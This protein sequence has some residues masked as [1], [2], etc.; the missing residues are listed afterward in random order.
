MLRQDYPSLCYYKSQG[1]LH[2]LGHVRITKDTIVLQR[3]PPESGKYSFQVRGESQNLHLQAKSSQSLDNWV[4]LIEAFVDSLREGYFQSQRGFSDRCKRFDNSNAFKGSKKF[5]RSRQHARVE[6]VVSEDDGG[7]DGTESSIETTSMDGSDHPISSSKRKVS[8]GSHRKQN[9]TD[10]SFQL[11]LGPQYH[12]V[13]EPKM[14]FFIRLYGY[15]KKT[16][17]LEEIGCTRIMQSSRTFHSS[18][19]N[20]IPD[21][22]HPSFSIVLSISLGRYQHLQLALFRLTSQRGHHCVGIGHYSVTEACT[23]RT[24]VSI[25]LQKTDLLEEIDPF[26]KDLRLT[27]NHFYEAAE[28]NQHA[29]RLLMHLSPSQVSQ[30]LLSTSGIDMANAKYHSEISN[31]EKELSNTPQITNDCFGKPPFSLHEILRIP[32]ET[33][34]VPI[35]FLDYLESKALSRIQ[36][37][38][39]RMLLLPDDAMCRSNEEFEL[40]FHQQKQNEYVKHRQFLLKKE[41]DL[42]SEQSTG[43]VC[44]NLARLQPDSNKPAL[45]PLDPPFKRSTFRN[46]EE[47][48]YVAT[49]M[50]NQFMVLSECAYKKNQSISIACMMS[51]TLTM[52]CPAAHTKGFNTQACWLEEWRSFGSE[53]QTLLHRSASA[54]LDRWRNRCIDVKNRHCQGRNSAPPTKYPFLVGPDTMEVSLGKLKQRL[55]M[56]DRLD[57][58]ASQILSAGIACVFA[59]LDLAA[60]GSTYHRKQFV[61]ASRTAFLIQFESLLSTNGKELGMLE[62]FGIGVKWLRTVSIQFRKSSGDRNHILIR[63]LTATSTRLRGHQSQSE[64][65]PGGLLVSVG[66]SSRY[67]AVLPGTLR[68]GNPFRL[69]CV[70]F[71]QGINEKQSFM[72][73]LKASTIKIQDK[74]NQENLIELQ[75]IYKTMYTSIVSERRKPHRSQGNQKSLTKDEV[76]GCDFER[77]D[78]LL[79]TL[80]NCIRQSANQFKK[81]PEI[82][83]FSAE[84][85]RK[86][87]AARVICCKSG[88]DRTAMSVTMEQAQICQEKW[89]FVDMKSLC[90]QMRSHGVRR[91]N[92]FLNT[93]ST[94]YAFNEMQR[95]MLPDC[96]KPPAGTYRAGK[97]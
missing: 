48:Q 63:P 28:T 59:S 2:L 85:C 14:D 54:K 93:H 41:N 4:K 24:S 67:L 56:Q 58:I 74:I 82:L 89:D 47:W 90:A 27:H 81:T 71:T 23:S 13:K 46:L 37:L 86:I 64:H 43:H 36:A 8:S 77:L 57:V 80:K 66:V 69:E 32:Q 91:R 61:H 6:S 83:T 12:S 7:H 72:N 60:Q 39:E 87:G 25:S 95:K 65:I 5:T 88:K 19:L 33:F 97:T 55:E 31:Y 92:V 78:G 76:F 53:Q 51:H 11:F 44:S 50:Q 22:I 9:C 75:R 40:N 45:E 34:T 84:F 96:Y 29:M 1:K 21:D 52:G 30:K 16:R 42:L 18:D 70:L 3:S 20:P 73:A 79:T 62:D 38:R 35:A 68:N 17:T 94:K 15:T 49:N 26:S 10:F